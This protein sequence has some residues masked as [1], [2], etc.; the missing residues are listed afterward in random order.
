MEDEHFDI[1]KDVYEGSFMAVEDIHVG[2][3]QKPTASLED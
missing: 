3:Q 1:D 2:G